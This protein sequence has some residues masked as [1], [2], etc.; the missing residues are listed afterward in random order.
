MSTFKPA[1]EIHFGKIR[2]GEQSPASSLT[3]G[4]V[5]LWKDR[6]SLLIADPNFSAETVVL[7]LADTTDGLTTD[8]IAVSRVINAGLASEYDDSFGFGFGVTSPLLEQLEDE[9]RD[10]VSKERFYPPTFSGD[11]V[12]DR[13]FV[14]HTIK[15]L[16]AADYDFT[17]LAAM[18]HAIK[19]TTPY[20]ELIAA[21]EDLMI[22]KNEY[23]TGAWRDDSYDLV[24]QAAA[25]FS[26]FALPADQRGNLYFTTFQGKSRRITRELVSFATLADALKADDQ[27]AG[28][29]EDYFISNT[30]TGQKWVDTSDGLWLQG[31]RMQRFAANSMLGAQAVQELVSRGDFIQVTEHLQREAKALERQIDHTAEKADELQR[32]QQQDIGHCFSHFRLYQFMWPENKKPLEK[33]GTKAVIFEDDRS[34]SNFYRDAIQSLTPHTISSRDCF[35]KPEGFLE[36]AL[37]QDTRL[38][39]ID[40]ENY[41]DPTAGI[42]LADELLTRRARAASLPKTKLVLWTASKEALEKAVKYFTGPGDDGLSRLKKYNARQPL[43]IDLPGSGTHENASLKFVITAKDPAAL[44]K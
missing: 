2:R 28:V 7:E 24:A 8:P 18:H 20:I 14:I 26:D 23:K 36:A 32:W 1:G 39:V 5:R 30:L 19:N 16:H 43:D 33:D 31:D 22:S 29:L 6:L 9:D 38:I 11:A 37:D 42:R 17:A 12:F 41:E 13:D 15:Q 44:I 21:I 4:I 34:Q 27:T 35:S 10:F 25:N 3:A 40:I